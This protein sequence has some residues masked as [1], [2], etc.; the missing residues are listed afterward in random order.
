MIIANFVVN[1]NN[2]ENCKNA[3]FLLLYNT[4]LKNSFNIG[5]T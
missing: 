2:K 4:F 5:L 1:S 3:E